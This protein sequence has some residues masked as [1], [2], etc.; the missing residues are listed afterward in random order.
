VVAA[1]VNPN[2]RRNGVEHVAV[3]NGSVVPLDVSGWCLLNR[4]GD[5]AI[6]DGV[7]PPRRVRRFSLPDD[8]PL[9]SRGGVIRLLDATGDEQDSVSY[10]RHE[11]RRAHGSLIF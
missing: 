6:L 1:Y 4:E 8:V 7:I 9:S 2:D 5:S 11:V 10:T 3:R